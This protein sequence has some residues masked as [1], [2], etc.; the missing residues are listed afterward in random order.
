MNLWLFRHTSLPETAVLDCHVE[1]HTI[2]QNVQ[3]RPG[4][5]VE[6]NVRETTM[7]I[8]NVFSDTAS[9]RSRRRRLVGLFYYLL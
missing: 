9:L 7:K 4:L 5:D 3:N 8:I 6:R 1:E 2:D